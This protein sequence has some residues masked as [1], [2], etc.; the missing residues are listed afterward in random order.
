MQGAFG[1]REIVQL[2]ALP[3]LSPDGKQLVFEHRGDLWS[4]SIKGGKAERLTSHPA[5]D[6]HPVFSPDGKE[7]AFVSKRDGSWQ[8]YVMPSAGGLPEQLSFHSDGG[9]PYAW[10]PDGKSLL[11]RGYGAAKGLMQGRFFKISRTERRGEEM[12]FD[13]YAHEI[14]LSPDGKQLLFTSIGS[15]LYRRGY[16]GSLA[17]RIWLRNLETGRRPK[18]PIRSTIG[19]EGPFNSHCHFASYCN[20][21][22]HQQSVINVDPH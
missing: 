13:G 6:T 11:I 9:T 3:T 15:R 7:L 2:G 21:D 19:G 22:E 14:S 17:S 12:L 8:T 1:E 5:F 18:L 4:A 10:F 16:K 20:I